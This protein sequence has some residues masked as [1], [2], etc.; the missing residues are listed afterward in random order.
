MLG[1]YVSGL[2]ELGTH[3]AWVIIRDSTVNEITW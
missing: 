3:Y 2:D 1:R